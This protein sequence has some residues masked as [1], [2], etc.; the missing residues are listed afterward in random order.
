LVKDALRE[1]PEVGCHLARD[2]V[3][4]EVEDRVESLVAHA[5][6]AESMQIGDKA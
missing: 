2:S 4:S 5:L 1:P 3:A 6:H